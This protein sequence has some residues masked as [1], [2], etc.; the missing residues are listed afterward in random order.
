MSAD[1]SAITEFLSGIYIASVA[2]QNRDGSMHVVP[3]WYLFEDGALFLPTSPGS[4]K[5]RNVTE[6]PVAS[7]M[8]D[9]RG[10]GPLRAASAQGRAE[11]LDEKAAKEIN[12]RCWARYCTP[13]GLADPDIGGLLASHDTVCIKVT[14]DHWIWFDMSPM[15]NGKLEDRNLVRA[16]SP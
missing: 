3:I 5:I 2:T 12:Q 4:V 6:R 1:I 9:S 7:V 15:F 8:V 16:C 14:P 11:V 13:A 10:P